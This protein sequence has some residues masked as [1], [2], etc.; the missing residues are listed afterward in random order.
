MRRGTPLALAVLALILAV[1]P[2]SAA[3]TYTVKVGDDYF[4][5]QIRAIARGD[6]VQWRNVGNDGHT[7][8]LN[9]GFT[10]FSSRYLASQ[11]NTGDT[12]TKAFPAAGLFGYYCAIH[13]GQTGKIK[14]PIGL[15]KVNGQIRITLGSTSV[16]G[17]RHRI[18]KKRNSGSWSPLATTTATSYSFTPPS[19]GTWTFRVRL[20]END[21]NPTSSGW[22]K[23]SITW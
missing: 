12:F 2:A 19:P 10:F 8:T 16:S 1:G 9:N 3:T 14:V 22:V 5:P 17:F 13:A 23:K 11:G 18:E 4:D 7:V 15:A 20:E 21:A 6:S